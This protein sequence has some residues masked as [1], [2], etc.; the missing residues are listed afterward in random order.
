MNLKAVRR[1]N[2]KYVIDGS[3]QMLFDLDADI[4]ER[5]DQFHRQT[6][7]ANQLRDALASWE[8]SFVSEQ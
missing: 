8:Q 4:G 1:D 3:T 6:D 5:D 7:I 2:W